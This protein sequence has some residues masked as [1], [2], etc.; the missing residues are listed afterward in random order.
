MAAMPTQ[1]DQERGSDRR[2]VG[3]P[4]R[5]PVTE[6]TR[7][8]VTLPIGLAAGLSA[9]LATSWQLSVLI[10]WDTAASVF[11]AWVW[12]TIATKDGAQTRRLAIREDNS[13]TGSWFANSAGMAW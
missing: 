11:L 2:T 13:R 3:A 4:G 7:L 8:L 6:R 5:G 12:L 1:P 10:G 9:A